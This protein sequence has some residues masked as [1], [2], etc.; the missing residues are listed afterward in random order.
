LEGENRKENGKLIIKKLGWGGK[1]RP[2][3]IILRR[4]RNMVLPKKISEPWPHH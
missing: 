4:D 2:P 3:G 1:D